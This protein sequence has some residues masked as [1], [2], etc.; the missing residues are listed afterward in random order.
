MGNTVGNMKMDVMNNM[1]I[2]LVIW[3]MSICFAC[4]QKD[5]ISWNI[6]VENSVESMPVSD[7]ADGV[8][9]IRL[10]TTPE[11]LIGTIYDVQV[12][13]SMIFILETLPA[14]RIL[15]FTADGRF[16]YKIDALGK[17]PEEYRDLESFTIDE[18]RKTLILNERTRKRIH[19]YDAVTGKR[20]GDKPGECYFTAFAAL[21]DGGYLLLGEQGLKYRYQLVDS[22]FREEG[23]IAENNENLDIEYPF[24]FTCQDENVWFSDLKNSVIY[25][26][27]R[28]TRQIESIAR[29]DFGMNKVPQSWFE[30][31]ENKK[32]F[33][34]E[35]VIKK[36]LSLGICG[37]MKWRDGVVFTYNQGVGDAILPR[38]CVAG[39]M[40][41][42]ISV[43]SWL[44]DD[45]NDVK[46][47]TFPFF[48]SPEGIGGYI[49]PQDFDHSGIRRIYP[50]LTM[51]DNY[52][53]YLIQN[54]NGSKYSQ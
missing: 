25:S 40:Q 45:Y 22:L 14:S 29:V 54:D 39:K 50:D 33:I 38:W 26:L 15:C 52:V 28:N 11:A 46:L 2:L 21:S 8:K 6:E 48:S 19:V 18:T 23:G 20:L 34:V 51:N 32:D 1:R 4:Q 17:G 24:V 16:R 43:M 53:L 35:E 13:D 9:Y 12:L 47:S 36:N 42:S 31:P 37:V 41:K 3:G 10:E 30:S 7:I 27:D 5:E 49:A 44:Y